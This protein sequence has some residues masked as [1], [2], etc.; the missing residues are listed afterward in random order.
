M[1][2]TE[3]QVRC[4]GC[5]LWSLNKSSLLLMQLLLCL[6]YFSLLV[7]QFPHQ[8]IKAMEIRYSPK[9]WIF[10]SL[11]DILANLNYCQC[12]SFFGHF[13]PNWPPLKF[14]LLRKLRGRLLKIQPKTVYMQRFRCKKLALSSAFSISGRLV[15]FRL[16]R[17]GNYCRKREGDWAGQRCF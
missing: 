13:L 1:V 5:C 12:E 4:W 17:Q 9:M 15:D 2:A 6:V 11:E 3:R 8:W 14:W 7:S 16:C 10:L